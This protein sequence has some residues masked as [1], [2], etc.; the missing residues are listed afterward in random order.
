MQKRLDGFDM[1]IRG[2][3]TIEQYIVAYRYKIDNSPPGDVRKTEKR[4]MTEL[5]KF[6][7]SRK[8]STKEFQRSYE[9]LISKIFKTDM[10]IK[11]LKEGHRYLETELIP[12]RES[13]LKQEKKN[14]IRKIKKL[15]EEKIGYQKSIKILL[16]YINQ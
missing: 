13:F 3:S 6:V 8:L 10:S 9:A 2:A 4:M 14:V 1:D 11:N 15:E 16:E 12:E 7:P 5:E